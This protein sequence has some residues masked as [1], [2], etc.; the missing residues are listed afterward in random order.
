MKK[1]LWIGSFVTDELAEKLRGTG[2]KNPASVTSQKNILEGLETVSGRT[3]ECVG[4]LSQP[5]YPRQK[6]LFFR[7]IG[8]SHADGANDVLVGHL[9]VTY[10]NRLAGKKS[11]VR[12]VKAWA[13]ENRNAE[14]EVFIYEMRS[15]CLAAAK[16]LKRIAPAAKVFL[17]VPDLPQFMD[18]NM[19]GVKKLLKKLDASSI[20]RDIGCVDGFILYAAKMADS[21]GLPDGKWTVM[22]GSINVSELDRFKRLPGADQ[23]A[24]EDKIVVTYSGSVQSGFR[25]ENLLK[26][27]DFLD[28][29]FELWITGAGDA[30]SLVGE[31]AK[32]DGR[33]KYF[34]FLPT[35]EDAAALQRRS[36]MLVN[37]RDPAAPASD[38]CFPSK[39]FEYMLTGRPVLTCR[40]GGIPEEYFDYLFVMDGISPRE[41]AEGIKRVC[42]VPREKREALGE[43]AARF[44]AKKKNNIEQARKILDFTDHIDS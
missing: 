41:I 35:R 30:S 26:A 9:N 10:L 4:L 44:V 32:K 5:G 34:G 14:L 3:F 38:Y 6:K 16:A 23:A 11:L 24:A 13:R 21:L 33:I 8:F 18:L 2:Y 31:Y 29:R 27:F 12:R 39:L 42:G 1:Y 36:S 19:S 28:G 22:E 40:L 7:E 43:S 15:A 20:R 17:I 25:I 37:M